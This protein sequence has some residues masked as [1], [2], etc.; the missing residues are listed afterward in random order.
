MTISDVTE[1]TK[2]A[3]NLPEARG[4]LVQSVEEGKP[5]DKA[6]IRHGDVIVEVDGRPIRNNRELIDYISYLPVGTEV[7]IGLLR[8]GRRQNVE[9]KTAQRPLETDEDEVEPAA[10]EPVRN[11]LGMSVQNLSAELRSRYNIPDNVTGVVVTDVKNVSAA[12]EANINEGDVIS[13]IQGQ[14]VANVDQFKEVVDRVRTGQRVRL[15]VTTPIRNGS[16]ISTYRI[17]QAP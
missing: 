1:E 17:L 16:P 13:E 6:G 2:E 9:A 15:Y 12:G 5:A 14:R 10:V 11:K 7:K 3:F 4:A 8:D